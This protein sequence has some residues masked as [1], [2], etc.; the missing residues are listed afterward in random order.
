MAE[1]IYYGL[2]N[3]VSGEIIFNQDVWLNLKKNLTVEERCVGYVF[4]EASLFPHLNVKQNLIYGLKRKAVSEQV[5]HLDEV[6]ELLGLTNLLEQDPQVLSGGER[7][8]RS[9]ADAASGGSRQR[10]GSRPTE[11]AGAPA[12]RPGSLGATGSRAE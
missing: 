2:E 8:R 3:N 10:Y 6:V 7:Q 12:D 9:G 11:P 5:F 1:R 4:Q